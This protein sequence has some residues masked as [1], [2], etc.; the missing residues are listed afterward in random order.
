MATAP[1]RVKRTLNWVGG[2]VLAPVRSPKRLLFTA[3]TVGFYTV[4]AAQIAAADTDVLGNTTTAEQFWGIPLSNYTLP[5]LNLSEAHHGAPYLEEG[6][7]TI[8]HALGNVLLFLMLAFVRGA[9]TAMQWMLNL[10]IYQ[11]ASGQ[12]DSAVGALA[13]SL[14]WP[15]LGATAAWAVF[16]VFMKHA[17]HG[18]ALSEVLWV[19]IAG[20]I[21]VGFIS[22]PAGTF[23][24]LD[25]A[26]TAV[27]GAAAQGYSAA[28]GSRIEN[29]AGL[30]ST[31]YP[32]DQAGAVNQ[33]GDAMWNVYGITPW[34]LAS[35]GPDLSVCQDVGHE[36]LQDTDRWK[37]ID[38]STHERGQNDDDSPPCADE[39]K[40]NCDVVRGQD[41]GQLGVILFLTI[42]GI[43]LGALLLMLVIYG[44]LALVEFLLLI[45]ICPLAL[46]A[47]MIPGRPRSLGVRWGE[48]TIGTLLTTV[49]L[50]ALIGGVM[51]LSGIFNQLLP[52][53]GM[54]KVALLNIAVFIAAFRIRS[55]FEN[56]TGM[57][58]GSSGFGSQYLAMKAFTGAARASTALTKGA[59]KGGVG[60]AVAGGNGV[61]NAVNGVANQ[62]ADPNSGSRRAM[63]A[64]GQK[65]NQLRAYS[66]A[67][68]PPASAATATPYY[69]GQGPAVPGQLGN[70][71]HVAEPSR[72]AG[73]DGTPTV[74]TAIPTAAAAYAALP[75][76]GA[77]TRA[78]LP[79][80]G[81]SITDHGPGQPFEASV[82]GNSS[83]VVDAAGSAAPPARL[84][85]GHRPNDQRT[86]VPRRA[87]LVNGVFQ[88]SSA[89]SRPAGPAGS[90]PAQPRPTT[91]T[92]AG[93]GGPVSD[94]PSEKIPARY[95][96]GGGDQ[97]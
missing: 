93:W 89:P 94:G 59:V 47:C 62:A 45:M 71:V 26:R 39:L 7:W 31:S 51:V 96:L 80:G 12:I 75:S 49:V 23:G 36:L 17:F 95:R 92:Q 77:P 9:I 16:S 21:A 81:A 34:C 37:A 22:N 43:A 53:W 90:R 63:A 13:N 68:T 67:F 56:M 40:G 25:E 69:N 6:M 83:I 3:W 28:A 27:G 86:P 66:A 20:V 55:Q 24:Q 54:F 38:A 50:T 33:L 74:R 91:R 64:A 82:P 19:L 29:S 52:T 57:R 76:G 30:P 15:L 58:T 84:G 65:V 97:A 61:F 35:F 48:A 46:A 87:T 5:P 44:V 60:A 78:A 11:D 73:G 10:T 8:F 2:A 88:V 85:G 4:G 70:N 42:I 14:F 1:S 32:N 18:A 41:Y 79:A 72:A